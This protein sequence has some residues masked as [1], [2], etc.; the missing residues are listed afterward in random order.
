MQ[1]AG[2]IG[3]GPA[4]NDGGMPGAAGDGGQGGADDGPCPGPNG[5]LAVP[6]DY[7]TIQ[8]AIDDAADGDTV[9]VAPGTYF[10]RLVIA[11]KAVLLR[12]AEGPATTIIDGGDSGAVI[13]VNNVTREGTLLEGFTIRNGNDYWGAGITL[14]FGGSPTIRGNW[15]LDNYGAIGGFGAAIGGN[16]AS[17]LI[18]SNYFEGNWCDNQHLSGVI[19]FVN[20]SSPRIVNNVIFGN[21]CRGINIT[22]P[23][24]VP[25]ETS[26]NTLVDNRTG[27]YVG[28][29]I[30]TAAQIYRNNV[31]VGGDIGF[32]VA[33]D[34]NGVN[35]P[36]WLANL[37]FMSATN[38]VG[39]AD[40]TGTFG[41][42]SDSPLF[43][44]AAVR[45]F[46]LRAGSA[47]IDAGTSEGPSPPPFD[48]DHAPRPTDGDGDGTPTID[49]GA[50]EYGARPVCP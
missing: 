29:Q 43:V 40:P 16:G 22:I 8:A 38:F 18:D 27:I 46:R 9:L 32:E 10:E 34:D 6:G 33:N 14:E 21:D 42:L 45:N 12:S 23:E 47:A 39:V 15:F 50:Y 30:P 20:H 31:I 11:G 19:S 28:A 37:V 4:P 49:L 25:T 17:P 3:G 5:N 41:N 35:G 1:A 48:F 44:D 26:N 7:P 2:G 13:T 36:T 24:H